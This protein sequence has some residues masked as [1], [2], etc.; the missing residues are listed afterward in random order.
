MRFYRVETLEREVLFINPFQVVSIERSE[1]EESFT[2]IGTSLDVYYTVNK[3]LPA[4][5][6]DI[7]RC[8]N[9]N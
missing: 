2:I 6:E 3:E 5:R 1:D 4:V 9:G 8:L 7:E